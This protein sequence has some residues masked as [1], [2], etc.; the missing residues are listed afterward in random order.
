[1]SDR[2]NRTGIFELGQ[3]P[4]L[5]DL[6]RV[7]LRELSLLLR[8]H[9]V[10]RVISY[11]PATQTANLSVDILQVIKDNF[12]PATDL[13]P[14]P[15]KVQTPVLLNNIIV[16]F[17]RTA[18]GYVTF[19]VAPG[20]TG[21]LHVQDRS[22]DQWRATGLPTDPVSAFAHMLGDSTFHPGLF[23]D[24]NP[25]IPPTSLV[26]TVL[27]GPLIHLGRLAVD[28]VL[29]GLAVTAAFTTYTTAVAAAGGAHA[30]II[31]PTPISNAAFIVALTAATAVLATSIAT[32]PS[33]KVFT[34]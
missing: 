7:A 14:N 3:N 22:I 2:E 29:K 11:N 6:F 27:E 12:T 25:I 9:S 16:K 1:M 24:T 4:E 21:E 30:L 17:P 32:W 31:P 10:A 8:A 23:P 19:P 15:V 13:D 5:P 20:D 26:A 28:P 34:E 33:L 18:A